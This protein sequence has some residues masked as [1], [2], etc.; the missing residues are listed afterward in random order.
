MIDSP[1]IHR[2]GEGTDVP[3]KR[4]ELCHAHAFPSFPENQSVR[5]FQWPNRRGYRFRSIRQRVEDCFCTPR[6]A[7]CRISRT[8]F[9]GSLG[10]P[11]S[12]GTNLATG[13]PR[14]VIRIVSPL[15][16]IFNN[17]LKCVSYN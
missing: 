17:S 11:S 15:E 1:G 4:A 3:Q 7:P 10:S 5:R 9:F 13:I 12:L 14:S 6:L 8:S 16:T 2:N